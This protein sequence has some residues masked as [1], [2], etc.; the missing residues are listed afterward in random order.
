MSAKWVRSK[1]W[2]D[3]HL[4]GPL[5]PVK[6]VLRA[7]SSIPLAIV[8]LS[9]VAVFGIF[10]SVPLGL[11]VLVLTWA[12]YV[13]TL[14]VLV[15][16]VAV[17]PAWLL[18]RSLKRRGVRTPVRFATNLLAFLSLA[19]LAVAG[20][21]WG[22]YPLLRYDPLTGR[23]VRFFASVIDRYEN[24]QVR[25]LPGMEMSE[26][27]F[28]AWWP[29]NLVLVLFV[30]NMV[31]ATV[32]RIEFRLPFVGVLTVHTGIVVISLGSLYYTAHK[33]EGDM[34]LV[35]AGLDD[36]GLPKV[37][38][39]E[40][41]FYDNT[42]VALWATQDKLLGWEQRTLEGVPRYNAYGLNVLPM[43]TGSQRFEPT[44]N[45]RV[46]DGFASLT[47][48]P[49]GAVPVVDQDVRF[50]IVG[51]A[52]YTAHAGSIGALA[53]RWA[54]ASEI[55]PA[56]RGQR[57]GHQIRVLEAV[58]PAAAQTPGAPRPPTKRWELAI[59][60]PSGRVDV[61]ELLGIEFTRAMPES[62]W[63]LLQTALP[64]G[65]RHGLV[66]TVPGAGPGGAPLKQTIAVDKGRTLQVGT[67]GWSIEVL[68]L[69]PEPPF[70]IVTK[71]FEGATS[72][73]AV[74][75]VTP[76]EGFKG[77]GG[78]AVK[79]F[80]RYVYHR[81]PEINQDLSDEL[82]ERGMPKRTAENAAISIAYVDASILQVYVDEQESGKLRSIVRFPAGRVTVTPNLAPD[83]DIPIAP[84][85]ALKLV[86]KYEGVR[87]E[88]PAL[89]D[90][91]A[92]DKSKIGNHQA[93][94]IAL[95]VVDKAGSQ[96]VYWVPFS[97]YI[98][99]DPRLERSIPLSGGRSVSV[100]FGRVRHEFWPPMSLSL[101]DFQMTPY[102]HST[103]PKDYAS[104]LV[105]VPKWAGA[106]SANTTVRKTSL[107]EPLLVRTPFVRRTDVP[108]VANL[109][110]YAMSFIA[111]SQYKFSQ[112]GWD[113]QGWRE[114]QAQADAGQLPRPVAR[115]T[116]LGVGNN[117]GIYIIASGAVL[118]SIGI[119]MAFYLKPW[120]VQR[121]KRRLQAAVARGEIKPKGRSHRTSPNGAQ[122][123]D[124]P[125][126][127][128]APDAEPQ[129]A[130]A[131]ETRS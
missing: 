24:V 35:G 119:P 45:L 9:L 108:E 17:L 32:R 15:G 27:E 23:G 54:K 50:E 80:T 63:E 60:T 31:V 57:N 127:Q 53:T 3:R 124:A 117:P 85:L 18:S 68:D 125:P 114:T 74:L 16:V 94:A 75:R 5:L 64:T 6:W 28:Y 66:I 89:V 73:V 47:N 130:S 91:D 37:G 113:Q 8:L 71:G 82:N 67:T 101:L 100:A 58:L 51:Y 110:G 59:D 52:P 84:S 126:A 106:Q 36:K 97:Q 69:L 2:D 83:Q 48:L 105:V 29:L 86:E 44:L 118:M 12:F 19:G 70:P 4:T 78:S 112:A 21:V 11:L 55:D 109:I 42:R 62:R 111:P 104:E 10:A 122:P 90:E 65:A 121:E 34:L 76:P 46:P 26:L 41:G 128:P 95:K 88:V 131:T 79:P 39:E 120:L 103:T 33:Q 49:K 98:G 96:G 22:A 13:L 43:D 123:H 87:V 1:A 7:L 25:R 92:A 20:W 61:M 77:S 93:A 14:L 99:I 129:P 30:I 115:F 38:R 107:N 56:S 102:P 72:S 81:F 40:T 116:I